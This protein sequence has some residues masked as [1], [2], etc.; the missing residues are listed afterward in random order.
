MTMP[1]G[2]VVQPYIKPVRGLQVV[3][4]GQTMQDGYKIAE[5][6]AGAKTVSEETAVSCHNKYAGL[7]EEGTEKVD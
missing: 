7:V 5:K 1:D 2:T 3:R 6:T 4:V